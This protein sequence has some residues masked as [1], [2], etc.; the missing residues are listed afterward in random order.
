MVRHRI[1]MAHGMN[2]RSLLAA[3]GAGLGTL[4]AASAFPVASGLAQTATGRSPIT[5]PIPKTGERIPVVGLGTFET[6]DVSPGEPR[7]HIREVI[8][9]FHQAGGRVIDTSPLY[10]MSE[11]S[12]GDFAAELGIAGDLFITNKTWTTGEWLSDNSHSEAQF[13]L[14]AERL[15]RKV[16]DVQQVH[17]LENHD[18]V[19]HLLRKWKAEGRVRYIGATQWSPEYYD[20]LERLVR[21]GGLDFIQVNYSVAS[22]RCE[23]RLL[24]AC[25]DNGVAVQINMPFEKARLFALVEKQPVPA[26]AKEIGAESWAQ[27]FLKFV[28]AH[29]AVTNVVPATSVPDHVTDNMG[30]L[31]GELPDRALLAQL[32]KHMEELRGFDAVLRQPPYPDKHYGGVVTWPFR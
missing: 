14:S 3:A 29:P 21:T 26:F 13:R 30:A 9:R 17:S 24:P 6:F 10:G 27:L 32:V 11:V 19:L 15:W 31:Y 7:D 28:M 18:Q 8:R 12:V 20:T 1:H 2:R 23:E 22:R 5:R 16:I 4:A 25:A